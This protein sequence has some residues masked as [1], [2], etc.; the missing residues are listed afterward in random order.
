MA[1]LLYVSHLEEIPRG[2]ALSDELG[3][4][5][6]IDALAKAPLECFQTTNFGSPKRRLGRPSGQAALGSENASSEAM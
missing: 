4:K 6:P 3:L 5:S 1:T 2:R